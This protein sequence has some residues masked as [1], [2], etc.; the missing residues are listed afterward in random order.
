[1]AIT[2]SGSGI[3]EV[4]APPT[5]GAG[6]AVTV[7]AGTLRFALAGGSPTIG[8]GVQVAV[9]GT[10]TLELAGS[11]SA[12]SSGA[13]RA[14]ILNNSTAAAGLLITGTNQIVGA[15]DGSG[16]TQVNAGSDLTANHIIQGALVIGGTP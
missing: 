7:S 6:T 9:S 1:R 14:N 13:N 4:V 11:A 12:L 5:L 15:I 3:M 10:A 8:A 16:T 2:K